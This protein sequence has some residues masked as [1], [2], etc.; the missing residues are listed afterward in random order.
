VTLGLLGLWRLAEIAAARLGRRW[1]EGGGRGLAWDAPLRAAGLAAAALTAGAVVA[2]LAGLAVWSVAGLWTFPDFWPDAFRLDAWTRASR[3]L[4]AAA[5]ETALIGAAA[6]AVSLA[7]TLGC[8]EAEHRHGLGRPARS[9]WLLYLPLV[10]PNVAFLTGLQTLALAA[11]LD[12][13]RW[14]VAA[15]HVVFVLP[16]VF[17]SLADPWRAWDARAGLAAAALG[18]G[19]DRILWA[20]RMPMLL[21]P[22]LTAAAVGFAVSVGQYLPTL[23]I[24]GGR[25]ATLATEAVALASGGDRRLIGVHALAQSAAA[26]VGFALAL[27]IPALVFRNRRGLRA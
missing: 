21:R 22:L 13:G 14:A 1:I 27:A 23:L 19:P 15:A 24:G 8:L 4:R 7:L 25:V 20:V 5:G 16:Y 17:L 2:G 10:V 12:G 6:L 3:G 11:G 9:L 26:F 18:A